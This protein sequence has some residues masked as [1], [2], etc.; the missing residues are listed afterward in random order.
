MSLLSNIYPVARSLAAITRWMTMP[1]AAL[2]SM[3]LA[4][5]SIGQDLT[6]PFDFFDRNCLAPGPQ[7]DAMQTTAGQ[8]NW[9]PLPDQV[10]QVLTPI[11]N[12]LSLTGWIASGENEKI[13]VVVVS[14]G[15]AGSRPV[16]G[17]TVGFYGVDTSAFE[18]AMQNRAGPGVKGVQDTP[19]R[20]NLTFNS[21]SNTGLTEFVTLGLPEKIE[22][23]DQVIASVIIGLK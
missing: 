15:L 23:P 3:A 4:T 9:S 12:P 13:E 10:L 22:G 21:V 16:E 18:K 11:A 1:M 8:K 19:N 2:L 6:T 17:C 5:S 20:I 7:F 14:K